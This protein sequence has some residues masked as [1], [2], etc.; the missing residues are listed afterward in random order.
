[1]YCTLQLFKSRNIRFQLSFS[2]ILG[3]VWHRHVWLSD[4]K[5]EIRWLGTCTNS[6][7]FYYYAG[8]QLEKQ[9]ITRKQQRKVQNHKKA[10]R[11]RLR[12]AGQ[13]YVSHYGRAKNG[14]QK[15]LSHDLNMAIMYR[16]YKGKCQVNNMKPVSLCFLV[17]I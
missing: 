17:H 16:M 2:R 7:L 13:A 15:F 6:F 14:L 3:V 12:E 5:H 9:K 11:K 8:M 1:M 10:K 4:F